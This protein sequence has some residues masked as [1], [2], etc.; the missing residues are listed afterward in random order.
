MGL[1]E[2]KLTREYTNIDHHHVMFDK[3][4]WESR[5]E[6]KHLRY[7]HSL[8]IPIDRQV[9]NELHRDIP[10]VPLLGY[11]ALKQVNKLYEPEGD[12][13]KDID[14]LMLS[15]EES[16]HH[17]RSHAIETHLAEL[18]IWAIDLQRPYIKSGL[19]K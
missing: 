13:L 19:I 1:G 4:S 15:I 14:K 5:T 9:H 3:K 7:N 17:P 6:S 10:I 11:H 18:A 16:S 8:I 12:P 2:R